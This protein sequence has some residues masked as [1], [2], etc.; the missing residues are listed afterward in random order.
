MSYSASRA[1]ETRT[2][3]SIVDRFPEASAADVAQLAIDELWTDDGENAEVDLA[4][5]RLEKR[6]REEWACP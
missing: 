5:S 2:I 6:A 4:Y 1:E 3:Q